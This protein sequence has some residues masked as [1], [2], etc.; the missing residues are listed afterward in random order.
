M[1]GRF[2]RPSVLDEI[3]RILNSPA[4]MLHWQAFSGGIYCKEDKNVLGVGYLHVV[5]VHLQW[6]NLMVG[7]LVG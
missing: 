3:V 6:L 2:G 1:N 7:R 5:S 4:Q